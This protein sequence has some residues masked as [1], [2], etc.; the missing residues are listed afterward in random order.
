MANS[1]LT[2]QETEQQIPQ[3]AKFGTRAAHR[4]ALI[5]GSVLIS[6][7][8]EIRRVESDGTS[9]TV[10]KLPPRVK[11]QKGTINQN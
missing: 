11:M 9:S 10:K 4:K 8:G 7:N 1:K 5:S 2:V 6:Q 3:L